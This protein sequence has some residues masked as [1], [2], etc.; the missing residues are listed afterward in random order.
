MAVVA[1]AIANDGTVMEP[2]VVSEV[3]NNNQRVMSS[4]QPTVVNQAMTP[5]NAATLQE[6]MTHVVQ[7]GTGTQAQISGL[8]VGGKTGTAETTPGAASHSWFA[9]FAAEKNVAVAVY[10]ATDAAGTATPV[11]RA[12]M[13]AVS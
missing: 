5:A 11:A 8:T 7:R 1:G 3:R 13:E 4:H 9:G 12:V 2:Y 6:M 10:L